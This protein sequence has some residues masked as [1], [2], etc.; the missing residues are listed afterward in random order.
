[1]D[2]NKKEKKNINTK[3]L[4][5]HVNPSF[6][7]YKDSQSSMGLQMTQKNQLR[8]KAPVRKMGKQK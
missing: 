1:V 8:E 7:R 6:C 5:L 4:F 2:G 3:P